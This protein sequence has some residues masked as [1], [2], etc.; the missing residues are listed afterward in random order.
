MMNNNF[1]ELS[2]GLLLIAFSFYSAYTSYSYKPKTK[3]G[4]KFNSNGYYA[5][6]FALFIGI[7]LIFGLW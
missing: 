2:I 1:F 6:V 7:L 3:M 4:S 5:A